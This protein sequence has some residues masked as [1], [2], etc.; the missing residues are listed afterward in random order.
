MRIRTH[1]A[2]VAAAHAAALTLATPATSGTAAP[3]KNI[4]ARKYMMPIFL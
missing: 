4:V 3:K 2:V 1:V